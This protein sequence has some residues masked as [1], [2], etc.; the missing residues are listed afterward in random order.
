MVRQHDEWTIGLGLRRAIIHEL[1]W[2]IVCFAATAA[3][4]WIAAPWINQLME[5]GPG[6]RYRRWVLLLGGGVL[7][8]PLLWLL[9]KRM[10]EAAGFTGWVVG[11]IGFVSIALV[12][13]GAALVARGA[14]PLHGNSAVMMTIAMIAVSGVSIVYDVLTD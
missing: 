4:L 11:C 12:A 5:E 9:W 6:A 13:S 2:G 8:I 7:A 3:I 1:I 14:G 10:L